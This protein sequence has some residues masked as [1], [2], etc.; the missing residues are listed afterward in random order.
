LMTCSGLGR[1]PSAIAFSVTTTPWSTSQTALHG[2]E[3]IPTLLT[4]ITIPTAPVAANRG[5][6]D[7]H[8]PPQGLN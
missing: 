5:G 1:G 3:T 8:A 2:S 7:R 6:G 4:S